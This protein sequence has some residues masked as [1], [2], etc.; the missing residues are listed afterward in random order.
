MKCSPLGTFYYAGHVDLTLGKPLQ[1][2]RTLC[3]LD[4]SLGECPSTITGPVLRARLR[5]EGIASLQARYDAAVAAVIAAAEAAAKV[6]SCCW[7]GCK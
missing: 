1:H 7:L 2:L 5:K 6:R 4:P 3:T